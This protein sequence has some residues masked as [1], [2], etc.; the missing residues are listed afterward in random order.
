MLSLCFQ[1]SYLFF[2]D[3]FSSLM[4]VV[5]LIWLCK[6]TVIL[7][8]QSEYLGRGMLECYILGLMEEKE[9]FMLYKLFL[10]C[11]YSQVD[12]R[13]KLWACNFCYQ[14]NQVRE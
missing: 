7:N 10:L 5:C 1:I 14:R 2:E 4:S 8:L 13:A 3:N 9:L 12:Y 6:T 11:F